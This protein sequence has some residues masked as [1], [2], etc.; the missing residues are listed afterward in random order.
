[1]L[2]LLDSS[3]MRDNEPRP[4]SFPRGGDPLDDPSISNAEPD[5]AEKRLI[6]L[7]ALSGDL[8]SAT[9]PV[10][11]AQV[12]VRHVRLMAGAEAALLAHV[13]EGTGTFGV[14]AQEGY[15][16]G[17]EVPPEW[18]RFPASVEAPIGEAIRTGR[19]LWFDSAADMSAKFPAVTEFQSNNGFDGF[20]AIPLGV[21][22]E[23]MGG[24]VLRFAPG[25]APSPTE[26]VGIDLFADQVGQAFGRVT[27][28]D[29]ER[30]AVERLS[31]LDG[32]NRLMASVE[33]LD[34]TFGAV[35]ELAVP[36][37][38]DWAAVDLLEDDGTIRLAAVAHR[39]PGLVDWVL[40]LRGSTPPRGSVQVIETSSS[41]FVPDVG[42]AL[43]ESEII[44]ADREVLD[45]VRPHS[46]IVAPLSTGER[47]LGAITF[48]RSDDERPF[49]LPDL[50]LAETLGRRAALAVQHAR[51]LSSERQA[52]SRLAF[53]SEVTEALAATRDHDQAFQRLAALV[54]AG[55]AD[56]CL[57][58]TLRDHRIARV[59][60]VG[61]DPELEPLAEILRANPPLLGSRHPVS[62][63]MQTGR[64]L[65]STSMT[66]DF[67]ANTTRDL[68]HLS[69]VT[70]LGF[71]SYVCAPLLAGGRIVGT[72]TLVSTHPDHA[73]SAD[74]ISL[75][76]EIG[77]KAG[78]RLDNVRL[79]QERDHIART[80]Q[81]VLLPPPLPEVPGFEIAA[82]YEA[83]GEGMEVGGDFY[84]VFLRPD[85][86]L[87]L[88]I[89]D[90]CGKGPEAAGVM[91]AT[92]QAASVIGM[93]ESR[94]CEILRRV[95]EVLLGAEFGRFVTACDV[96][97]RREPE[98]GA[99]LTCC[100][101]GHPAPLLIS[102]E[103]VV[104]LSAR[105]DVLGIWD[106]VNLTNV[107]SSL[108][109]GES[110]ALYTDGVVEW[111][112]TGGGVQELKELLMSVRNEP[113]REMVKRVEEWLR[114]RPRDRQDDA[115]LLLVKALPGTP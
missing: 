34:A 72:L 45:L 11:V 92:R 73:F 62:E 2:G 80:L 108:S 71:H 83:A 37:F 88:I 4:A 75:A 85:G 70:S 15:D 51:L 114:S 38:A 49:E 57:I 87:G 24:L 43:T 84:D 30:R 65:S 31:L 12:A 29:R 104:D 36:G 54:T 97:L 59:A 111:N 44:D 96:R 8:A 5:V 76:E 94:P 35:A 47:V 110:I 89:G 21:G 46:V 58:D 40:K 28:I 82:M 1:M 93:T 107:P 74:E 32:S 69:A 41:L 64:T 17:G 77:R 6:G 103:R 95:N 39:D 68:E 105:G 42:R 25:Q 16:E 109:P 90:V 113:A 33:D 86:S 19:A 60:V 55:L 7:R 106:Q 100:C 18:Q 50:S 13:K 53:L 112:A 10:E 27:L 81:K 9:T 63:V 26:R 67:L 52:K 99:R 91:G 23:V 14:L 101:A 102:E 61:S 66:E 79:F 22:G 98:G 3:E 115:A 78:L 56:I 20:A 48:I